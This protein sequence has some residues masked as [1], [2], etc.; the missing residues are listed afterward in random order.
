MKLQEYREMLA[1]FT[2]GSE[3]TIRVNFAYNGNYAARGLIRIAYLTLFHRYGYRYILTVAGERIR[4]LITNGN[5]DESK[6]CAFRIENVEEA[7][8]PQPLRI[9]S[10]NAEG[11]KPAL[12]VLIRLKTAQVSY[13]GLLMPG[14]DLMNDPTRSQNS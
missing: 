1:I 8:N 5:P 13:H 9:V 10:I 2:T 12:L 4:N 11:G 14:P 6:I 7:T 3:F